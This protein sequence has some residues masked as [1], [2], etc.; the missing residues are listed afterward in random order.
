MLCDLYA[1]VDVMQT[2]K[3]AYLE[4]I[5]SS[6]KP[7]PTIDALQLRGQLQ[8]GVSHIAA[9]VDDDRTM[10][11]T[12]QQLQQPLVHHGLIVAPPPNQLLSPRA[13]GNIDN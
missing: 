10:L 4:M 13:F 6:N 11:Q 7:G 1:V 9:S 5:S 2:A 3:G 12:T 8:P